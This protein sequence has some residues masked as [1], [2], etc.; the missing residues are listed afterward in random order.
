MDEFGAVE[1]NFF[2]NEEEDAFEELEDGW[3]GV[4]RS[5]TVSSRV[6][7][8]K[9][10]NDDEVAALYCSQALDVREDLG[11]PDD[12]FE[13]FI[14]KMSLDSADVMNF[15]TTALV[16]M[17]SGISNGGCERL[18]KAPETELRARFKGNY[19]FVMAQVCIC[20][21]TCLCICLY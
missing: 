11:E 15:D 21:S 8:I 17:V 3:V 12:G 19:E 7:E 6:F 18:M 14:S 13:L 2:K 4:R 10:S 16:A 5:G 9:I 20:F 1:V